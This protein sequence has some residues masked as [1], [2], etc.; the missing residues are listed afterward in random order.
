MVGKVQESALKIT[1]A[2][3]KKP[4]SNIT[5]IIKE[6]ESWCGWRWKT[7]KSVDR[8]RRSISVG[9]VVV[10]TD[11]S[12]ADWWKGR[13]DGTGDGYFPATF[14]K[15]DFNKITTVVIW[16]AQVTGQLIR[17]QLDFNKGYNRI[18]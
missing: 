2:A 16:T 18:K 11:K 6:I 8:M 7:T 14:V 5:D 1:T 3:G 9:D 17:G 12:N 10:V 13:V 15:P 4:D